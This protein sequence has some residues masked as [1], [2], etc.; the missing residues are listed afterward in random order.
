MLD[1]FLP[2][3]V[4]HVYEMHCL[5]FTTIIHFHFFYLF[6]VYLL[7][8]LFIKLFIY[9]TQLIFSAK[10]VLSFTFCKR[11]HLSTSLQC[12]FVRDLIH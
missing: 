4:T 3:R 5:I 12:V 1:E 8:Y 9:L 6:L 10:D 2:P 7:V 11:R